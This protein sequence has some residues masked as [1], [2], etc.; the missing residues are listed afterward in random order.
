MPCRV[1][2]RKFRI[3]LLARDLE[4]FEVM[5]GLGERVSSKSSSFMEIKSSLRTGSSLFE[6]NSTKFGVRIS[7]SIT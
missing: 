5:L 6:S 1:P 3:S 7:S 2:D 4:A